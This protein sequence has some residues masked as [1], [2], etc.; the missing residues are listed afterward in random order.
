MP[1]LRAA[2]ASVSLSDDNLDA[3]GPGEAIFPEGH[4]GQFR[5]A[6][7]LLE[8]DDT[9]GLVSCDA[10]TIPAGIAARVGARFGAE[11]HVSPDNLLFTATHTHHGP[12]TIDTLGLRSVPEFLRRL[13][14]AALLALRQAWAQL[15]DPDAPPNRCHAELLFARGQEAT[16][17]RNSRLLLRDGQVGWYGYEASDVVRPTGPYDPDLLVLTLRGMDGRTIATVLNH[18]VHNI[19]A[20]DPARRSP[21]FYGLTAQ[22]LER[23]HGGVCL[24]LPG[25]LGSTHNCTYDGSGLSVPELVHRMTEAV[26]EALQRLEPAL[27]GPAKCL[28]QSFTYRV[29][30]F[31][32]ATAAAAVKSYFA[33]YATADAAGQEAVFAAERAALAPHAGEER[34]VPLQV[35]RLGQVALVGIPGEMYARLGLAIRQ[36]SPLRDTYV[37]GLANDDFGYIPDAEGYDLGGYQAWAHRHCPA[38]RGTG[39]AMVQQALAMLAAVAGLPELLDPPLLRDLRADEALALQA[40]YNRT[41]TAVRW[42]FCPLGWNASLASC[43]DICDQVG[44]GGR[45]DVVLDNG[46]EIVGWAFVTALDT[47][48]AYL[49]IGI[50]DRYCSQGL[51]KPLMQAVMDKCRELG[52]AAV[53]LI[54]I[55]D[56]PRAQRLYERFGFIRTGELVSDSGQAF[57]K[58]VAEL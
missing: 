28:K 27:I 10:L 5:A 55:Q 14:T 21:G 12:G 4:E 47:P 11:T 26:E 53:E 46:R 38:A 34:Q 13:E 25:A 50:T 45:Y 19:G 32:E 9:V 23:H 3:L 2:A 36:H 48:R 37:V 29:R 58:M 31:D 30:A 8:A 57:Y 1:N 33:R 22:E 16:V 49:G 7:V 56:N 41:S 42:L 17:G 15:R 52:K 20:L 35:I 18:S 44:R 39:E 51:G 6:A 40:F 43:Q 24:F 54:V